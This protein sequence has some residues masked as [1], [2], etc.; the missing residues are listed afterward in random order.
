[1]NDLHGIPQ[2]G[3]GTSERLD[4][5]GM[6][7]ILAALEIGYRHI[8]TAQTYGSEGIIGEALKRSR[9]PR[10]EVFVTTKIT[11]RYCRAAAS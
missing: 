8:D 11:G 7:A 4:R 9:L 5:E 2:I 6:E 3:F 10:S 1:M